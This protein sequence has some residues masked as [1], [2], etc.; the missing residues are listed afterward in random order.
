[1][2]NFTSMPTTHPFWIDDKDYFRGFRKFF[3]KGISFQKA[4]VIVICLHFAGIAALYGFSNLRGMLRARPLLDKPLALS[5]QSSKR[6]DWP[7]H[8]E[9]QMVATWPKPQTP[10]R[11]ERI[12]E[13]KGKSDLPNE[14]KKT[15]LAAANIGKGQNQSLLESATKL[16]VA[17]KEIGENCPDFF[18]EVVGIANQFHA[19]FESARKTSHEIMTSLRDGT[20]RKSGELVS[21]IRVASEKKLMEISSEIEK[22][23][24]SKPGVANQEKKVPATRLD[25]A[26]A[27][28]GNSVKPSAKTARHYTLAAGD[29]L[30][31]VSRKLGVSYNDLT[32]VNGIRDPRTL[33]VG[34]TLKVPDTASL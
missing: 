5:S 11:S 29:N 6:E 27:S 18:D 24:V 3:H 7:N 1:M 26:V 17:A 32:K 21:G 30:Y 2:K 9:R 28:G 10:Q 14:V 23:K 12:V 33:R 8:G 15:P 19:G 34:Q 4:F 16:G 31:M 25:R 13:T 20:E 22:G